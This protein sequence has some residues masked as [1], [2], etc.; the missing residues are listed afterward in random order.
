M[1]CQNLVDPASSPS[2]VIPEDCGETVTVGLYILFVTKQRSSALNCSFAELGYSNC[3]AVLTVCLFCVIYFDRYCQLP[4]LWPNILLLCAMLVALL[5]QRQ[6][7]LL[8]RDTLCNLP[9]KLQTAPL[10][11]LRLSRYKCCLIMLHFFFR[12]RTVISII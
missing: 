6:Q 7:I 4:Q 2:Q 3:H 11:W 8:P 9:R 1:A 5:H 12:I 10:T